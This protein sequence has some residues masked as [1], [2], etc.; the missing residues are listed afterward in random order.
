MKDT[1]KLF[2]RLTPIKEFSFVNI[3][4]LYSEAAGETYS[5]GIE[6]THSSVA[7]KFS[8]KFEENSF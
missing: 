2:I 8:F 5:L 4:L 7:E 6:W 3:P 1:R